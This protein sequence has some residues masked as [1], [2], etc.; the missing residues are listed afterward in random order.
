VSPLLSVVLNAFIVNM[1]VL[2]FVMYVVFIY[3]NKKRPAKLP[4]FSKSLSV[5]V[6]GTRTRTNEFSRRHGTGMPYA[7]GMI[8]AARVADG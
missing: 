7:H 8:G 2:L 3:V 1:D 6:L 5:G 4:A